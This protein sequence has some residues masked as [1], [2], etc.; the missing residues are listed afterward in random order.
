MY[1]YTLPRSLL[2]PRLLFWAAFQG[3]LYLQQNTIYTPPP[4]TTLEISP[5]RKDILANVSCTYKANT[6]NSE[7]NEDK[8]IGGTSPM[9]RDKIAEQTTGEITRVP[10]LPYRDNKPVYVCTQTSP[11]RLSRLCSY[12]LYRRIPSQ[13]LYTPP[14]RLYIYRILTRPS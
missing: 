11:N 10:C 7:G 9:S 1:M 6:P 3:S 4:L 8:R 14:G 13:V 5:L 2:L 12:V